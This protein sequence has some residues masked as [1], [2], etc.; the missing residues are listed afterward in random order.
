MLPCNC[1]CRSFDNSNPTTPLPSGDTSANFIDKSLNFDGV[2]E[3]LTLN[4]AFASLDLIDDFSIA[5]WIKPTL[6][7]KIFARVLQ[8]PEIGV[9]GW[10]R[11]YSLGL[12]GNVNLHNATENSYRMS[13]SVDDGTEEVAFTI[14]RIMFLNRSTQREKYITSMNRMHRISYPG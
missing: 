1:S 8:T 3:Y 14:A 2:D 5:V 6:T 11:S 10:I 4:P 13:F 9:G 12:G 7:A